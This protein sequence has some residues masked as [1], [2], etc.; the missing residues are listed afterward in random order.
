MVAIPRLGCFVLLGI[1]AAIGAGGCSVSGSVGMEAKGGSGGLDGGGGA[2]NACGTCTGAVYTSC[3]AGTPTPITCTQGCTPDVGCTPCSG[4]G[5]L[6]VGNAVHACSGEGS[7]GAQIKICDL[8]AGEVCSN[9]AC[10]SGCELS[11]ELPSNQGCEFFAVDLDLADGIVKPGGGPWGVAIANAGQTPATVVIE[12]D[13]S[14]VG[15]PSSPSV[16]FQGTIEAG[17]LA[18]VT[19]PNRDVDCSTVPDD[20]NAPG[21]C[22]S[23]QAFRITSSSPVVVY[24]FNNLVHNYSTDASLLLPTSAIGR[25][26]RVIGWPTAHSFPT[27]LGIVMRAYVTIVGTVAGTQVTVRPNWRIRGNDPIPATPAGETI[28]MTIGPFDVLNLESDDS[29][30][31]ECVAM[32]APPYC[33]DLTGT[34]VEAS[35]PVVVFSGTEQ[36]GVGLPYDAPKPPSWGEESRGCCNQHLEEQLLP[37]ESFGR[38]FLVTRSPLRSNPQFTKWREPDILRFVGVAETAQVTT[39]LPPPFDSFTLDPGQVLQTWTANDVTISS[40]EPIAVAQFLLGQDYVEPQPKGDP[41]FTI[42]PPIEQARTEYVFLSPT[43]WSEHWVVIATEQGTEV[44]L[45]G[46][47]ATSCDVSPIGQLGGKQYE[48]RRCALTSGVHRMSGSAP[49]QI[50]VYG[51][52]T[53]DAYSF[54][55]GANVK[56]IY[57]PPPIPH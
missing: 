16:L 29:T 49:F 56:K 43:G 50:M 25:K 12:K 33:A 36:S 9:G 40:T 37:I 55:G 2:G 8:A 19:L 10:R 53:A 3:N 4:L 47:P 23:R 15:T 14:A 41:S 51:Y 38:D 35:E 27:P 57:E 5:T 48:S 52:A 1:A 34:L 7:A 30:M 18:E 31:E 45:D 54:P 26:Y 42:F 32:T 39:N 20:L 24:Q 22:L 21:T 44:T 13:D 6:C 46:V 11:K 28:T 17:N